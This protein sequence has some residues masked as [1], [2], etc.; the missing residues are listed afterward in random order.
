MAKFSDVRRVNFEKTDLRSALLQ[1]SDITGAKFAGADMVGVQMQGEIHY[2]DEEAPTG[3]PNEIMV[4]CIA[5]TIK[6]PLRRYLEAK[7]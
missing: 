1:D 2:Y 6:H 3:L 4:R 7:R 5:W